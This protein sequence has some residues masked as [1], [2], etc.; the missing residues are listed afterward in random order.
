M[1]L[2]ILSLI[3]L[4][5]IAAKSQTTPPRPT[6][7]RTLDLRTHAEWRVNAQMQFDR[8]GRLLIL[9]RDKAKLTPTGN[10]HLL[11][12]TDPLSTSPHR[13]ELAFSLPEEPTSSDAAD[14]WDNFR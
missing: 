3:L 9:Y 14:R 5:S 10:W 2:E 11:R 6:L 12:L 4:T 7:A 8:E 13:E 1:R